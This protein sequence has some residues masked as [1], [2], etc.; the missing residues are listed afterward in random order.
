MLKKAFEI[1]DP[2]Y[3][4]RAYSG[5]GYDQLAQGDTIQAKYS[6]EKGNEYAFLSKDDNAIASA[7][8][9]LATLYATD[10]TQIKQSYLYYHKAI[11]SFQKIKDTSGLKTSYQNLS[12]TNEE[13]KDFD[14]LF[15]N[16]KK[17]EILIQQDNDPENSHYRILVNNNLG[18]YHLHKKNYAVA[19]SHFL[20]AIHDAK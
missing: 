6:F 10:A 19:N 16:T 17:L 11:N 1:N 15:I 13:Q 2:Y 4:H 9:D 12:I 3:I 18:I 5:L 14:S 7:H 8:M 20:K